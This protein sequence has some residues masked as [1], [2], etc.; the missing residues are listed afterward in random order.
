M[1]KRIIFIFL[2]FLFGICIFADSSPIASG[3]WRWENGITL[4]GKKFYDVAPSYRE[5]YVYLN[6]NFDCWLYDT[7]TY[8]NGDG[9]QLINKY[10]PQ[11][12]EDAGYYIDYNQSAK[13][14]EDVFPLGQK[15][16]DLMKSKNCDVCVFFT[17]GD[18][19]Q[20]VSYDKSKKNYLTY[21]FKIVRL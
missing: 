10:L 21:M 3:G 15:L 5:Q 2:T 9:S 8:H 16:K 18:W 7:Y 4:N 20:V 12:I 11:W 19:L 14:Y 1:K 17:V 6:P 13:G